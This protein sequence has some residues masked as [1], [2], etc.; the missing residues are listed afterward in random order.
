MLLVCVNPLLTGFKKHYLILSVLNNNNEEAKVLENL[1]HETEQYNI[2]YW[3][4]DP[5]ILQG[6]YHG[7]CC[8]IATC[9]SSTSSLIARFMGPTWGP[10]GADRPQWAPCWPH[11]LCYLGWYWP[12]SLRIFQPGVKKCEDIVTTCIVQALTCPMRQGPDD[13]QVPGGMTSGYD[14]PPGDLSVH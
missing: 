11:E 6:E 13:L 3:T 1:S 9:V 10:S 8:S 7:C 4:E 2:Q 5:L 14:E 12:N